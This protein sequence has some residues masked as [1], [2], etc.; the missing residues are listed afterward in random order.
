MRYFLTVITFLLGMQGTLAQQ[1]QF[2]TYSGEDDL[3]QSMTYAVIEDSRGYLWV[4]TQGGGIDR[5]DGIDFENFNEK[6]DGLPNNF[7]WALYEDSSGYLWIGTEHGLSKYNGLEFKFFRPDNLQDFKVFSVLE[8]EGG[9]FLVGSNSGLYELNKEVLTKL[10]N[11]PDGNVHHLF[12]AVDGSIW[13]STSNGLFKMQNEK[14]ERYDSRR[15]VYHKDFRCVSQDVNGN[16]WAG[17]YAGGIYLINADTVAR[18]TAI[19]GINGQNVQVIYRSQ[20]DDMW[21]G[22]QDNGLSVWSP[23]DSSFNYLS[24]DNGLTRNDIRSIT[25]DTWGNMWIATTGGLNKYSGRQFNHISINQQPNDNYVYAISEDTLGH[26]WVSASG[27]GIAQIKEGEIVRYDRNFGFMDI[28]C[29]AIFVDNDNQVWVGTEGRGLAMY[30]GKGFSIFN[31][32]EGLDQSFVKDIL[33]DQSGQIWVATAGAGLVKIKMRDSLIFVEPDTTL[34]DSLLIDSTDSLLLD[35]L[36]KKIY[37]FDRIPVSEVSNYIYSIHEDREGRLWYTTR[38]KGI[39]IIEND[40]II[41]RFNRNNG[42]PDNHIR[43]IV[44]DEEGYIWLGTANAGIC[45]VRLQ[46]DTLAIYQIDEKRGLNSNNV[47]LLTLDESNNLWAGSGKGVDYISLDASRSSI[48]VKHFDK[49]EGFQGVETCTNSVLKDRS[50]RLWFGTV[51][52][53]TLHIPDNRGKDL[54]APKV[55]ITEIQLGVDP[56]VNSAYA[57]WADDWGGIK[58]G[59]VVPYQENKWAFEFRG[60][61]QSKPK[62]V[63]YKWK[64]EGWDDDWSGPSRQNYASYSRLDPGRYTFQVTASNEDG[65]FDGN[66]SSLQFCIEPPIWQTWWFKL[67]AV[68]L[69]L[70]LIGLFIRLRINR[71]RREAAI[72]TERLEMEKSLIQL[73]Q[74]ALQLQMNP[75]FI[76]NVLNSIQGLITKKDEK[77]ARYFLAKFSKLMR[78]ILENSRETKI[79][80]EQEIETLENYLSVERFSR[81]NAFEFD[82]E[83]DPRLDVDEVMIPPMLLQ[84]F[85]ENAIIHGVGQVPEGGKIQLQ[86]IQKYGTL[87]C[88]I[89]DNGP[90]IKKARARKSQQ[91]HT[92]KS[93]ALEVTQERLDLLNA[94]IKNRSLEIIDLSDE[95]KGQ[96]TKVVLRLV[97]MK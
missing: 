82:V 65:V 61:N 23:A 50:G 30:N 66:T 10:N 97:M 43:S 40:S 49:S 38:N 6:K 79:T 24:K 29:K 70:F 57:N 73:E 34:T 69:G 83:V 5:F 54:S 53:L 16:I 1:Y 4:G 74:K 11:V 80:L 78:G 3:S 8:K 2:D 17:A 89:Q 60:I 77:T 52:G 37:S 36:S 62:E 25:Q 15:L 59:L 41:Y 55:L 81:G 14:I 86:F 19:D 51:K 33:Q 58:P 90:G 47:Y 45:R 75:H 93:A 67:A 26:L 32:I 88:V 42:L 64:L 35:T 72:K 28:R 7:V 31:E 46:A 87:E 95:G 21:I 18:L 63:Q 39:G 44:E 96:G 94:G 85:V 84:P 12:K 27:K 22:T 68:L 20:S 48:K 9:S 13:I 71:V 76:F 92:H 91:E 56:L